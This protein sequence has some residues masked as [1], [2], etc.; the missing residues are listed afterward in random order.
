LWNNCR[1]EITEI[2]HA[3]IRYKISQIFNKR[4]EYEKISTI[5]PI[6]CSK[7]PSIFG[8][9][10][11]PLGLIIFINL[12]PKETEMKLNRKYNCVLSMNNAAI[13]GRRITLPGYAGIWVE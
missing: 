2:P 12:T 9:H 5:I 7:N 6:N 11:K 4:K 10:Y 13:K 3:E 1:G 8:A